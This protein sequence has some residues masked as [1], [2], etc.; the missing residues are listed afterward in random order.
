MNFENPAA[1]WA[2]SSL[3]LLVLFSLWRQAAARTVVPSVVLWKKI[4]ERNP[5][6]R[7]LRRPKWRVELLLQALAIAAAVAALAGPFA[8]TSKKMCGRPVSA[9][10]LRFTR[11][12]PPRSPQTGPHPST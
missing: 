7:A 1:L 10:G 4:P 11:D 2:L 3:A 6:I 5:P 12:A 8:T 9:T